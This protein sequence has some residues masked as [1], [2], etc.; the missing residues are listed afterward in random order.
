MIHFV[1]WFPYFKDPS[2]EKKEK[3]GYLFIHNDP[4][5]VYVFLL[6]MHCILM[7]QTTQFISSKGIKSR[8]K[9]SHQFNP[10]PHWPFL[11]KKKNHQN[12]EQSSL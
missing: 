10:S 3:S 9:R 5:Y 12:Q 6:R 8:I 11:K 2:I 4:Y 7:S 1:Y